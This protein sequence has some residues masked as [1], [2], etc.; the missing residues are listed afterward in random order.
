MLGVLSHPRVVLAGVQTG[1]VGLRPCPTAGALGGPPGL[2]GGAGH[3]QA[4][5]SGRDCAVLTA[6]LADC[7][8][9]CGRV[10]TPTT[11]E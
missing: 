8:A 5:Q 9:G 6:L 4:M 11:L 7:S 1:T 10:A 2:A 3:Q